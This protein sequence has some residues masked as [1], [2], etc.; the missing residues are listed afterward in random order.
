MS[1]VNIG[2]VIAGLGGFVVGAIMANQVSFVGAKIGSIV[3][4]LTTPSDPNLDK[5]KQC[6]IEMLGATSAIAILASFL[7]TPS[8]SDVLKSGN[9]TSSLNHLSLTNITAVLKLENVA[10]FLNKLTSI[11][12]KTDDITSY[13]P[14]FMLALKMGI[15]FSSA[16]LGIDYAKQIDKAM[17]KWSD[18]TQWHG[19]SDN[20]S[21]RNYNDPRIYRTPG[22]LFGY[23]KI[24]AYTSG[25]FFG[26]AGAFAVHSIM[27]IF[28]ATYISHHN[29]QPA[30]NKNRQ[31]LTDVE[32]NKGKEGLIYTHTRRSREERRREAASKGE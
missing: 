31:Y 7:N 17:Y 4:A 9:L 8:L 24:Q 26:I 6:R 20:L 22:Y 19:N 15:L 29:I 5:K 32:L 13:T 2:P 10:N 28:L 16:K 3:G 14:I 18:W 11:D 25:L 27:G 12:V 21:H 30:F 23:Q 1:S